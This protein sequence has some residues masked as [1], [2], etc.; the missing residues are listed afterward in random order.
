MEGREP[1][2]AP[3]SAPMSGPHSSASNSFAPAPTMPS[4]SRPRGHQVV[5]H[6][7]V[8]HG[9]VKQSPYRGDITKPGHV[10]GAS[11]RL[12]PLAPKATQPPRLGS[13]I[14]AAR[15]V[16]DA[17][18]NHSASGRSACPAVG[19]DE[20]AGLG[21]G[22]D[23]SSPQQRAYQHP[24]NAYLPLPD[25]RGIHQHRGAA[26][27]RLPASDHDCITART[28]R[29]CTHGHH[30]QAGDPDDHRADRGHPG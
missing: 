28:E 29:R 26:G 9:A 21:S 4:S 12:L 20:R 3:S 11:Q 18:R 30:H 16:A 5:E 10:V 7:G 23:P 25:S 24:T 14:A 6:E 19:V 22:H 2:Q 27:E 8:E 13:V 15:V 1:C 17:T